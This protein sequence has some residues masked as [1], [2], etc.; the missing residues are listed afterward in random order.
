MNIAT[1]AVQIGLEWDI[2]TGAVTVPIY[3]VAV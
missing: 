3:Q 1:E 2:R